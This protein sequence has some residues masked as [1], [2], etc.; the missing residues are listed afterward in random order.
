M[1]HIAAQFRRFLYDDGRSDKIFAYQEYKLKEA[2]KRLKDSTEQVV[3]ASQQL[4]A[5]LGDDYS[6][7]RFH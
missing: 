2:L 6:D 7:E 1:K 3:R 5:C 4:Q